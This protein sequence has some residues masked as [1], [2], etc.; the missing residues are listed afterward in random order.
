M[1]D[2]GQA[3]GKVTVT[4]KGTIRVQA[5]W[6]EPLA[7]Q[8]DDEFSIDEQGRLHMVQ[9]T[10]IGGETV[11]CRTVYNRR[12]SQRGEAPQPL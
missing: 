7:G 6:G 4:P 1:C 8:A 3:T 5:S 10:T 12:G 2:A 9:V 11:R